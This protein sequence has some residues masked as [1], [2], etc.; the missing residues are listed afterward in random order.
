MKWRITLVKDEY[1][2]WNG[3]PAHNRLSI[4]KDT[5]DKEP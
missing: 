5:E 4:L 3:V 1:V 2:G